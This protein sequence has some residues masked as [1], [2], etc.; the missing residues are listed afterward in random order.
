MRQVEYVQEMI[1]GL[2]TG[3]KERLDAYCRAL[4]KDK[5]ST[6][7]D[8]RLF[9]VLMEYTYK[10]EYVVSVVNKCRQAKYTQAWYRYSKMEEQIQRFSQQSHPWFGW[11]EN[12]K[13]AK[14]YLI[15]KYQSMN[16]RMLH[17]SSDEDVIDALPKLDSH[18][19]W[20]YI[21][22]G[23]KHKGDNLEQIFLRYQNF[24]D[25]AR[26]VG[27]FQVPILIGYRTQTPP[28][29]DGD[30]G[31]FK[32]DWTPEEK[33]K[34]RVVSM[35]DMFSNLC[36]AKF[37]L[38][39]QRAFGMEKTYA[40]GKTDAQIN[41]LLQDFR[42]RYPYWLCVDYSHY[43]Q[44]LSDW[45]INDVF[46]IFRAAFSKDQQFDDE[47]W[48]IVRA[49]TIHKVF[50]DGDG[51]LVES[52]KGEPSG[53]TLTNLVDTVANELM[54]TT[55]QFSIGSHPSEFQFMIMGDDNIMF[56]K[57]KMD[58]NLVS[59]YL[60]KNFGIECNASKCE[61]GETE[62]NPSFLS[63][64]WTSGGAW[65][66]PAIIISKMLHSERFRDYE[67]MQIDPRLVFYSY[68]MSFPIGMDEF[69]DIGKFCDDNESLIKN[70]KKEDLVYASGSLKFR[71]EYGLI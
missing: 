27:H 1:E 44:S 35:I 17:Y 62:D 18:S 15:D 61:H 22:T 23:F 4:S 49:S 63:R 43:D 13:R 37:G 66:H 16:L 34:S 8:K 11:N 5:Y 39:L 21:P 59:T 54:Q 48:N 41:D 30:T 10:P 36:S 29:F 69:V 71:I 65:R 42:Y 33:C 31:E 60:T 26:R 38:P 64:R 58:E 32:T 51:K 70:V 19:G 68:I 45:L 14:Q 53:E 40:G 46:D 12:Y 9:A 57:Y 3:S 20:S 28:P 2:D 50:I 56:T 25:R 47:L 6:N 55:Y 52:S 67:K 24:E 7:F